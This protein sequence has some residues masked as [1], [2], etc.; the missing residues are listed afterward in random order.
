[1]SNFWIILGL[2]ALAGAFGGVVNALLSGINFPL[3][4]IEKIGDAKVLQP[5]ILGNIFV[6]TVAALVSWGLYGPLSTYVFL[7]EAQPT[8][9]EPSLTLSTLAGAILVG[10]AG[11]KWF[12]TE[13]DKSTLKTAATKA[14]SA[15]PDSAK[16][17]AIAGA[18]PIETL[19]LV[20][21]L[22]QH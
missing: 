15:I 7:G 8:Q 11:A 5:G 6:S 20:Q 9:S 4:R 19:R 18:S 21:Q 3:P 2:I 22:K 10:V 14:S 16:T 17:A 12:T 1:M 13:I